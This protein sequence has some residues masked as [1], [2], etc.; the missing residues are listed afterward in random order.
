MEVKN[1]YYEIQ[2]ADESGTVIPAKVACEARYWNEGEF[3]R[4]VCRITL[5]YND[6]EIE[7][8]DRDFFEAFCRVR[9]QLEKV[10][11]MPLCYGASRN[12]FP[13]GMQRDMGDGLGAYK[14]QVGRKTGKGD[15]VSIFDFGSDV[16][17][18]SV[19]VQE[20]FFKD[21]LESFK[22]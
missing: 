7:C 12:V 11:L 20:R 8:S 15:G 19:E 21:W 17:P 3:S 13:S 10:N 9:E 2:L 5:R 4:R 14:L 18:V 16:A 22:G 1:R 6:S